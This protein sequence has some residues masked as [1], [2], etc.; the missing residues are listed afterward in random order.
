M[1][2]AGMLAL[3]LVLLMGCASV[4]QAL[5]DAKTQKGAMSRMELE[6]CATVL[7]DAGHRDVQ[8]VGGRWE[9]QPDA[10]VMMLYPNFILPGGGRGNAVIRMTGMPQ[11]P[12]YTILDVKRYE[13][14]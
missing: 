5:Q 4:E 3:Y 14:R 6:T 9:Y 12:T 13:R 10:R 8:V 1:K 2:P 11:N 7:H